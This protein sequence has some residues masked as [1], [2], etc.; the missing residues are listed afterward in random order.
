VVGFGF[1]DKHLTPRIEANIKKGV[2]LVLI[3]KEISPNTFKELKNATKY[4]LFEEA[5]VG[6]TRVIYKENKST[7]QMEE[8]IDGDFWQLNEFMEI[9]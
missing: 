3:T 5:G 4:I 7:E 6:K 1:N 2:P 8:V 9:L